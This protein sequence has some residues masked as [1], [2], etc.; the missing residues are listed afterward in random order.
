MGNVVFTAGNYPNVST[1]YQVPQFEANAE[2]LDDKLTELDE[3]GGTI[4]FV[5]ADK[6][7][8]MKDALTISSSGVS[9]LC[10]CDSSGFSTFRTTRALN[11]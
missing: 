1:S 3:L 9:A 6:T 11:E 2:K 4:H 7:F 5:D 8:Y 10:V